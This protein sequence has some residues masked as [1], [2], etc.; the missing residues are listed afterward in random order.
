MTAKRMRAKANQHI[1]CSVASAVDLP[2]RSQV[3]D[4]I[5]NVFSPY[6]ALE[7][8]RVLKPGGRF[9]LVG[10]GA[11]HL[12]ELSA[13]IYDEVVPHAGNQL[14]LIDTDKFTLKSREPLKL[15]IQVEQQQIANLLAMTP[16]YWSISET[17]KDAL[18]AMEKLNVTLHFEMSEYV[19]A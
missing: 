10:P 14:Q 19:A 18:F 8:Y 4:V 12:K 13:I 7:N 3:F 5:Y 9:I 2:Y 15:Q 17:Q 1:Q 6:S 16:Y 11:E